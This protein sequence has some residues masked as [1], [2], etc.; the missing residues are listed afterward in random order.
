MKPAARP[1]SSPPPKRP[2]RAAV[3][4]PSGAVRSGWVML[5]WIGAADGAV[6]VGAGV[7]KVRIPR[8]P[9]ENPPRDTQTINGRNPL[10]G[11][12]VENLSPAA[13]LDMGLDLF[14]KGVVIVDVADNGYA[15]AQ[16]FQ[17]GDVI[18]AVN[19]V[20]INRVGDLTRAL[21]AGGR[22]NIVME[23]GGRRMSVS[24]SG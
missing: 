17:T 7:E 1:P 4:A 22:W 20:D 2:G 6:R 12:K 14:T 5:R 13:A 15:A 19:G 23:R 11:A 16:G 8:L 3:L 9:P 10:G 18:R 21:N 24:F